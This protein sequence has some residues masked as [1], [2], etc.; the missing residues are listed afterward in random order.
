MGLVGNALGL[1]GF[2]WG[3]IASKLA[4]PF[5][6]AAGAEMLGI[7]IDLKRGNIGGV[8]H[9]SM[10]LMEALNGKKAGCAGAHS[11][12]RPSGIIG[13]VLKAG[14]TA[15]AV[16][17]GGALLGSALGGT[18]LGGL[19]KMMLGALGLMAAFKAGGALLGGAGGLLAG[20][21]GLL[22][23][24]GLGNTLAGMLPGGPFQGETIARNKLGATYTNGGPGSLVNRLPAN[25]TFE[26]LVAAFMIDAVKDMQDEAKAK[27]DEIRQSIDKGDGKSVSSGIGGFF[28]GLASKLP[29]VGRF[30]GSQQNAGK[31]EDSRNLMFEELK[32]IMQ[33]LAQMQQ[34][35]SNVLNTMHE[36]A[37]GAIR[38]IKA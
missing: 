30:F 25:A 17:G 35:M 28:G 7:A 31:G 36:Q 38:H 29:V 5:L 15:A 6:G 20:G 21:A 12:D 33:K 3:N 11:C 10:D 32:N 37:M 14:F 26:D 9:N 4:R 23:G 22:G 2:S 18:A 19:G 13:G 1:A 34:A 24:A 16:I 8:I 27:M